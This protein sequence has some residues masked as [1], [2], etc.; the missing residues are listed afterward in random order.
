MLNVNNKY[1]LDEIV[2]MI[3]FTMEN[4]NNLDLY[5][6]FLELQKHEIIK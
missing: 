5:G 6:T 2:E 3:N 4:F 1:T